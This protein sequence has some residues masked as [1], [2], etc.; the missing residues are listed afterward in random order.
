MSARDAARSLV[1]FEDR[2]LSRLRLQRRPGDAAILR[3]GNGFLEPC[4]LV[5]VAALAERHVAGGDP[6]QVVAPSD[7]ST[8]N[9]ASRM[10]LGRVLDALGVGHAFSPVR[11][12]DL[13][14]NLIEVVRLDDGHDVRALAK[15]VHDRVEGEDAD[16]AHVLWEGITEVGINIREHAKVSGY[17]A[18]QFMPA[19]GDVLFAVADG[20]PGLL[21]TLGG[22]GARTDADALRLALAGTSR[23]DGPDRGLGLMSTLDAVAALGGELYVASGA[24]SVVA[25][26]GRRRHGRVGDAFGGTLLQGRVPTRL[27]R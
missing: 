1:P 3:L 23:L 27:R 17:G 22:R 26:R 6:L 25:T 8:S 2:R 15:L 12:N 14:S 20:G 11:E 18:A 7:G 4:H 24:A 10:R 16:A 21:G 19:S 5:G 9:Y 13:R